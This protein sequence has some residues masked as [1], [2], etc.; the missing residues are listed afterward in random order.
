MAF[1]NP[2][3]LLGIELKVAPGQEAYQATSA[4]LTCAESG[5][6]GSSGIDA[7]AAAADDAPV[8]SPSFVPSPSDADLRGGAAT[9]GSTAAPVQTA[10]HTIPLDGFDQFKNRKVDAPGFENVALLHIDL[11]NS[12]STIALGELVLFGNPSSEPAPDPTD[13]TGAAINKKKRVKRRIKRDRARQGQHETL[14]SQTTPLVPTPE[15]FK[16]V[17]DA[18]QE[19]CSNAITTTAEPT[20]TA[21]AAATDAT[22]TD[23]AALDAAAATDATDATATDAEA[24]TTPTPS[25]RTIPATS[26]AVSICLFD[27]AAANKERLKEDELLTIV[28]GCLRAAVDAAADT[29]SKLAVLCLAAG[30]GTVVWNQLLAIV[31]TAPGAS[32]DRTVRK[33]EERRITR[34]LGAARVALKN[35]AS[36]IAQEVFLC[37]DEDRRGGSLGSTTHHSLTTAALLEAC[38]R[39][40][41]DRL[42]C[43]DSASK[44]SGGVLA[45]QFAEC[46]AAVGPATGALPPAVLGSCR[47]LELPENMDTVC[48]LASSFP[49]AAAALQPDFHGLLRSRVGWPGVADVGDRIP[50]WR[51]PMLYALSAF[52]DVAPDA[53]AVLATFEG[54][55]CW[56]RGLESK[57][58]QWNRTIVS[59]PSLAPLV[60]AI[61]GETL[62]SLLDER[63]YRAAAEYADGRP[64]LQATLA[65]NAGYQQHAAGGLGGSSSRLSEAGE[66]VWQMP[67][68]SITVL[69]NDAATLAEFEAAW[70]AGPAA[71]DSGSVAKNS[72][73]GIDCEW[74]DPRPISLVQVAFPL[75]GGGGGGDGDEAAAF[76][77]F[78]LD[79][80]DNSV[81]SATAVALSRL[82]ASRCVTKVVFGFKQDDARLRVALGAAIADVRTNASEDGAPLITIQST[83]D[84]QIVVNKD[85]TLKPVTGGGGAGGG[86]GGSPIKKKH[87]ALVSLKRAVQANLGLGFD[88]TC[89]R[90]NWYAREPRPLC[91]CFT[92]REKHFRFWQRHVMPPPPF[93]PFS[94]V[95]N[96]VGRKSQG[97]VLILCLISFAARSTSPPFPSPL[98]NSPFSFSCSAAAAAVSKRDRRPL[99]PDQVQYAAADAAVLLELREM[100]L[101]L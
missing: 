64:V 94:K 34:A 45:V 75:G 50:S 40:S 39:S 12:S 27:K 92:R 86:G 46:L 100:W 15:E 17:V 79:F 63:A 1:R 31:T 6:V 10:T 55:R 60:A 74:R 41:G 48:K 69:V 44:R 56:Q 32:G 58:V 93:P 24:A 96:N 61:E 11:S 57:L 14:E 66:Q 72:V 81:L 38:L 89:Q 30:S 71:P 101:E 70:E 16:A 84:L 4:R 13:E 43:D 9:P 25:S 85:G 67:T 8:P 33:I 19:A 53:D 65:A 97:L 68:G 59:D 98:S 77:V 73:C 80:V 54:K 99:N 82:L 18:L 83:L 42:R 35:A 2:V 28:L 36:A 21:T 23:A 51:G 88:K 5:D 29:S 22:A 95:A 49:E 47:Q 62:A 3:R 26:F 7:A 91:F 78:L 90:S 76:K 87:A 37:S 52:V 20:A